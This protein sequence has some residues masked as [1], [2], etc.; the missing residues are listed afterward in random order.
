MY[1]RLIRKILTSIS[2]YSRLIIRH[3]LR[4]YFTLKQSNEQHNIRRTLLSLLNMARRCVP[5]KYLPENAWGHGLQWVV[6][7]PDWPRGDSTHQGDRGPEE[8][9]IKSRASETPVIGG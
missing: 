6:Q 3:L 4:L 8:V 5:C 1:A 2:S 7:K 9:D